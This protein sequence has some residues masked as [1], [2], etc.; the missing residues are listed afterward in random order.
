MTSFMAQA[1]SEYNPNFTSDIAT[2]WSIVV[3]RHALKRFGSDGASSF[4]LPALHLAIA[5]TS[6]AGTRIETEVVSVKMKGGFHAT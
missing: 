6:T 2:W 3:G 4:A 1:D 5:R